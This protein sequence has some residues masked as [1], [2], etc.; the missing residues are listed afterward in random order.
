[1]SEPLPRTIHRE[2]QFEH[3]K[4]LG[5]S[6]RWIKGQYCSILTPVGIVG[7]G[8]YDLKVPA[9]FDQAIAIA[10][11]TPACPL[12]EPEDLFD[13]RIV[14][15][16]PKAAAY[17][18]RVG[19]TGREAVELMLQASQT[20]AP[21]PQP[22]SPPE[23]GIRVK[24]IDHVTL[25]VK[26]LERSRR[27]Y[28]DVLGMR[29]IHRPAFSFAGLWFQAGKTQIHLIQEYAGSGPAGNLLP[30]HLRSARTQHVAFE[31]E[32]AAATVPRLKELQV[33]ILSG[34]RPRPDGYIQVFV[35][36]PD[37]HVIELC[38]P[39]PANAPDAQAVRPPEG[40]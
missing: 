38:S 24:C 12:V 13:A 6:N 29:E 22:A 26:D 27:F 21:A 1:M 37:G 30:E 28:V 16:T 5:I 19:M 25:V 35:T 2:L 31:V 4:A 10:R 17:G 18:I 20:A 39:P 8:I 23:R 34:P 33:P 11:G 9:E 15:V 36:D 32:D 3:G 14:G 40:S 7:C